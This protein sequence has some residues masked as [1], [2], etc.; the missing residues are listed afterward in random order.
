MSSTRSEASDEDNATLWAR[1]KAAR[2]RLSSE[3]D[4]YRNYGFP[5]GS[6]PQENTEEHRGSSR[7]GEAQNQ[8]V[9][10]DQDS[11][12]DSEIND[13]EIPATTA[14][15]ERTDK[16][17]DICAADG[18]VELQPSDVDDQGPSKDSEIEVENLEVP[19]TVVPDDAGDTRSET[20]PV[21]VEAEI[22]AVSTAAVPD[23]TSKNEPE[24]CAADSEHDF[25][26]IPLLTSPD[27]ASEKQP[28]ACPGE[29]ECLPS[30]PPEVNNPPSS[31]HT[32][33]PQDTLSVSGTDLIQC[34]L[35]ET[36]SAQVSAAR[37]SPALQSLPSTK[38][39]GI[40][41]VASP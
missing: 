34:Q 25:K 26:T 20:C 24:E 36:S 9:A 35:H 2:V 30:P 1:I 17:S 10:I 39:E 29:S 28:G 21:H 12:R 27:E 41:I 38:Q 14:S 11:S 37:E 23:D 22:P 19:A 31:T 3:T 13:S 18:E 16:Q 15:D 7:D 4:F 33:T 8:P 5:A 32:I 6:Q 40:L